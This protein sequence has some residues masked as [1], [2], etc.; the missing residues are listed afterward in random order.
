MAVRQFAGATTGSTK[1]IKTKVIM[2]YPKN[3]TKKAKAKRMA[4]IATSLG[5]RVGNEEPSFSCLA[6]P[7][8]FRTACP[9]VTRDK[10][11]MTRPQDRGR[12]AGPG[13]ERVPKE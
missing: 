10:T 3:S 11:A 5:H 6:F 9:K 4:S 8:P 12:K 2:R 7:L 1:S 13:R